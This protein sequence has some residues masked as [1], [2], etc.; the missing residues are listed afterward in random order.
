[1]SAD[2]EYMGGAVRDISTSR[3]ALLPCNQL[4]LQHILPLLCTARML[5][6]LQKTR[7]AGCYTGLDNTS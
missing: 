1:M 4:L 6:R 5:D 7:G 2:T 3:S